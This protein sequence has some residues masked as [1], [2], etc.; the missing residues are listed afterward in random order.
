MN[1]FK[2]VEFE[3]K[4]LDGFK[5]EG[6]EQD[7]LSGMDIK[8]MIKSYATQGNCWIGLNSD[9]PIIIAGIYLASQ[10]V[11]QGWILMNLKCRKHT[12]R[13]VREIRKHITQVMDEKHIHRLQTLALAGNEKIG[14]FLEIIGFEKEATLRQFTKDKKDMELYTILRRN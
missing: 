6:I 14:R 3:E 7:L 2:V 11:G 13:I 8:K 10:G 1:N 12:K 9:K 5:Y 4:Y